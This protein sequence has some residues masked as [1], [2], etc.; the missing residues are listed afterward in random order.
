MS[1]VS[2]PG[3]WAVRPRTRALRLGPSVAFST[4]AAAAAAFTGAA[5]AEQPWAVRGVAA[6]A[7]GGTLLLVGLRSPGLAVV[8]AL[9]GLPF[10]GLARRML[11]LYDGWHSQDPLLLVA[12]VIALVIAVRGRSGPGTRLST[13][14]A[15]LLVV[16]AL[17]SVNPLGGSISAGMAGLLFVAAP[18][19]WFFV[20]RDTVDSRLVWA[21]LSSVVAVGGF[22]ALYGLDQTLRGFPLWDSDW[23]RAG[24]YAALNVG[25]S[26][27][28]FGTFSSAAEYGTY[29]GA[30]SVI[31]IVLGL[32]GK[33]RA[34]LLVP[35][36][37]AALF[38]EGSRGILLLA[39]VAS[40]AA[41]GL[42]TRR[43]VA[44]TLVIAAVVGL[45]VVALHRYSGAAA[46]GAQQSG[47]ALVEHQVG[48]LAH[49]LNP[50]QSTLRAHWDLFVNG[51]GSAIHQPLG[52]GT[53]A[54]NLAG[55]RFG[56]IASGTEIDVSNAFVSLGFVGG[57]L[58][59]GVIV[60]TFRRAF[61]LY[62]ERGDVLV[63]A[64]CGVLLAALGQWLN[65]GY[66]A[67]APLVWLLVGWLEAQW[68][69]SADDAP[70]DADALR[71]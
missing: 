8:L 55:A 29:I 37:G 60:L 67:L 34:L 24:G 21:V 13:L 33:L 69:T 6:L 53:G 11:I 31:C 26:I 49:P 20:G 59:V 50:S 5:I 30:A 56:G 44:A 58:F 16:A 2:V 68:T 66:Y 45:G 32:H 10:L 38:L 40:V 12:P 18:L 62:R 42:R 70:S 43:L 63:L 4:C 39:L 71:A 27:R 23:L 48:G 61:L 47:N 3:R 7:I 36:L 28:A 15:A 9:A 51:L 17:E 57:C 1:A 41:V 22:N 14:V 35:V 25:G 65:G 52:L 64:S 46:A 19:L 54:T